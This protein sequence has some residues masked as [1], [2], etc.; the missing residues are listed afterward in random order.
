MVT[1]RS[2]WSDTAFYTGVLISVNVNNWNCYK[3]MIAAAWGFI[4]TVVCTYIYRHTHTHTNIFQHCHLKNRMCTIFF[5]QYIYYAWFMVFLF[6]K[7]KRT[8]A[9]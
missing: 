8:C 4:C 6:N 1:L 9:V 5:I 7:Q 2:G 3:L